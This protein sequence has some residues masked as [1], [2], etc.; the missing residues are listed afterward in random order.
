MNQPLPPVTVRR[1]DWQRDQP[2]IIDIRTRVFVEEQG[3]PTA[4]ELDG[5][6]PQCHHLLAYL[7]D[8]PIGTVRLLPD[9]RIGRL[10]VLKEQRHQGSG[11][12]LLREII[13]VAHSL[14]MTALYLHAQV[15]TLDFYRCMGFIADGEE[16]VE[17]GIRHRNM[18]LP[19][20]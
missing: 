15:Q 5:Q 7:G 19:A 18:T 9:G 17:A 3:V 8:R 13:S 11:G 1:A 20:P 16:F 12:Q 4:I 14:G 2:Q 10:A 6:D